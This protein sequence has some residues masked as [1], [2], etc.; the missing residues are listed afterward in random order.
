MP[1]YSRELTVL[2]LL[3][4]ILWL[5]EC[6]QLT[7]VDWSL[8]PPA[9]GMSSGGMSNPG[10]AG[11]SPSAGEAGMGGA[12][13]EGGLSGAAGEAGAGGEG[14]VGDT[15][16][17]GTSGGGTGGTLGGTGGTLGGSGG[18]AGTAGGDGTAGATVAM[19]PTCTTAP[20][21]PLAKP[22]DIANALVL[23]DGGAGGNG[24]RGGRTGLK[25]SCVTAKDKLGLVQTDTE[26]VISLSK[27][28]QIFDMPA[29]FKIPQSLHVV[30]PY[31][32]EIADKWIG[33]W[34]RAGIPKSL[35]C[36]GVMPPDVTTWLTGSSE[37]RA[38][39]AI[40]DT[41][42]YGLYEYAVDLSGG[43]YS[44]SCNGWTFAGNDFDILARVGS[45]ISQLDGGD[46]GFPEFI[47][48]R[49]TPFGCNA[50]DDHVLCIAYNKTQ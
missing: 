43:E 35:V 34:R 9:G 18:K 10:A 22:A 32:I 47:R 11:E 20:T 48:K 49:G 45:T 27:T 50:A 39:D 23:F 33:I 40:T 16:G 3:G 19:H 24:N 4:A 25:Q 15:G 38:G 17:G 12:A 8:I 46:D 44:H 28:D 41:E 26:A 29:N 42:G 21:T 30:S 13:G 36:S 31:G 2:G 7:K 1:S 37:K 6:S 5:P 14:G